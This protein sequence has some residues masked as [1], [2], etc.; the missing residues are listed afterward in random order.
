MT[1]E[2][3]KE[4]LAEIDRLRVELKE[5]QGSILH[6]RF[7]IF[8][9]RSGSNLL[10]EIQQLRAKLDVAAEALDKIGRG[11]MASSPDD[12]IAAQKAIAKIKGKK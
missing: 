8:G 3:E 5:M 7:N 10:V 2:R 11:K 6:T 9:D 12:F 4:L 1:H